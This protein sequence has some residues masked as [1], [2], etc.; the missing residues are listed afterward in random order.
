MAIESGLEWPEQLRVARCVHLAQT[1]TLAF[2]PE[3]YR[4]LLITSVVY[5]VYMRMRLRQLQ[6]WVDSWKQ[7]G[8]FAG[9]KG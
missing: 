5:R 4:G 1:N 7:E 3:K 9:V 2:A 8:H 6:P